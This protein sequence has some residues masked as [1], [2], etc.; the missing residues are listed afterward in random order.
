MSVHTSIYLCD[1]MYMKFYINVNVSVRYLNHNAYATCVHTVQCMLYFQAHHQSGAMLQNSMPQ[2]QHVKASPATDDNEVHLYM[3]TVYVFV[4]RCL[5]T[6][7]LKAHC[8][9]QGGCG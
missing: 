6:R 8:G 5:A 7:F 4:G 1:V 9:L 3:Y 2:T